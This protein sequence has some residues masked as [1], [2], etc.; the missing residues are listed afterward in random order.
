MR[1]R[2]PLYERV[3]RRVYP[4]SPFPIRAKGRPMLCVR[5]PPSSFALVGYP[6]FAHENVSYGRSYRPLIDLCSGRHPAS[7]ISANA[8]EPS[9]GGA[10]DA[11]GGGGLNPPGG[12]AAHCYRVL[13]DCRGAC[14]FVH[15][16][17]LY[18][19]SSRKWIDISI[20]NPTVAH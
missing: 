13:R 15:S 7:A 19:I 6:A 4:P 2:N 18:P 12:H 14:P 20:R 3:G 10:G 9:G 16:S 11:I 5:R 1:S 17:H 8:H